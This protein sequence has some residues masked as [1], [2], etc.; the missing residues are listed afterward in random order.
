MESV[1]KMR[2]ENAFPFLSLTNQY[3]IGIFN[4]HNLPDIQATFPIT[5]HVLEKVFWV[6]G[7]IYARINNLTPGLDDSKFRPPMISR[8]R[9]TPI[10]Q[11]MGFTV[12]IYFVCLFFCFFLWAAQDTCFTTLKRIVKIIDTN[13]NK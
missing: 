7:C 6:K 4:A 10:S 12:F 5:R 9:P 2:S 13:K 8:N 3:V 11:R 1:A